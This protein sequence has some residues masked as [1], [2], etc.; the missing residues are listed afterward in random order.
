MKKSERRMILL[1]IIIAIVIIVVLVKIRNKNVS[2]ENNPSEIDT[3][4]AT[5]EFTEV[6]DD[7]TLLNTSDKLTETKTFY[8]DAYEISNIQITEQDGQSLILADVTN[9]SGTAIDTKVVKITFLD[10]AGKEIVTIDGIVGAIE[11]G[12]T[13]QLN[14]AAAVDFVNAYDISIT[15]SE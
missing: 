15:V 3:E 14:S 9:V 10:K 12:E 11:P 7:G 8:N 4:I 5:G 1:L 13:V 6:L 2:S